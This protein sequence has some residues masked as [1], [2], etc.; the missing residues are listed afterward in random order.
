MSKTT[1]EARHFNGGTKAPKSACVFACPEGAAQFAAGDDANGRF[2][3]QAYDGGVNPHW[4][5][6][7]FAIDLKGLSFASKTLPVLD[8]HWTSDR[9]GVTTK[10]EIS[11]KVTAEG[12]F[13]SNAKAQELRKDMQDGFPM[14]AS[15]SG[16]PM[17]IEQVAEGAFAEVNGHKLKG[18]GAIWRQAV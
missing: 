10:Q 18:P 1:N 6:G 3:L 5:W 2:T 11:G 12:R 16:R 4:Y 17:K 14:Q 15:L 13:L 8:S 9:L 7:N